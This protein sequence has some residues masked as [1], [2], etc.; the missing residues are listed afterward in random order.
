VVYFQH[1]DPRIPWFA[2]GDL[3]HTH[4][5]AE[6][7]SVHLAMPRW[8]SSVM[9]HMFCHAAHHVCP[10]IPCYRLYDAQLRLNEL[11][12]GANVTVPFGIRAWR[13]VFDRCKL[14]DY[15]QHQ[16][17]DFDGAPTSAPLVGKLPAANGSQFGALIAVAA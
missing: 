14:Y 1:T 12:Q 5:G 13:D 17:L 11:M 16:W 15:E 6:Q 4:Y 7:L 2:E 8:L 9:H 3:R 10:S